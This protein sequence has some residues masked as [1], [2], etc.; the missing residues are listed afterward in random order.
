MVAASAICAVSDIRAA[1]GDFTSCVVILKTGYACDIAVSFGMV[2]EN[3][4]AIDVKPI[5]AE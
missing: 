1:A 3:I 5:L 2:E 4:A